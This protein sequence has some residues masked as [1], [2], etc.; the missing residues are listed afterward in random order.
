MSIQIV[1]K[2]FRW[3]SSKRVEIFSTI[4]INV[5][6]KPMLAGF[7][8]SISVADDKTIGLGLWES[9]AAEHT[10]KHRRISFQHSVDN[11]RIHDVKS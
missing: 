1:F 5:L 8:V 9:V 2:H 3:C 11:V 7:V 10:T 6:C 4:A